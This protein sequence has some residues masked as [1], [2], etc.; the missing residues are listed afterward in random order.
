MSVATENRKLDLALLYISLNVKRLR[1]EARLTQEELAARCGIS[2]PR[3]SE[4]ERAATV[5]TLRT[6]ANIAQAL[7][8]S[9]SDL[10]RA[11]SA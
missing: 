1:V 9:I 2:F 4:L 3:I 5:P 11:P 8:C 7:G 10:L 6:L